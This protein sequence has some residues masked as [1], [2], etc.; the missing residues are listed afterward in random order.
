MVWLVLQSAC[1]PQLFRLHSEPKWLAMDRHQRHGWNVIERCESRDEANRVLDEVRAAAGKGKKGA[2]T[3]QQVRCGTE[4]APTL[5]MI[6]RATPRPWFDVRLV[7][8]GSPIVS[9]CL[10]QPRR[11]PGPRRSG[12]VRLGR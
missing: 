6:R 2:R 3:S 8:H 12:H 10:Q 7:G 1:M 9:V 11:S 4:K 5:K